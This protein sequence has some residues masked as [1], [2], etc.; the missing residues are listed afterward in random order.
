M[1]SALSV[2]QANRWRPQC[3]SLVEKWVDRWDYRA[4]VQYCIY[5]RNATNSSC[6]AKM[7][8]LLVTFWLVTV[9][10]F[11]CIGANGTMATLQLLCISCR[12]HPDCWLL[13]SYYASVVN[14]AILSA[15]L[16]LNYCPSATHDTMA[17]C[18][19]AKNMHQVIMIPWQ[20]VAL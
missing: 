17:S 6:I 9:H 20:L 4:K 18:Y 11:M 14:D 16:L 13:Y 19:N 10:C 7:Q 3:G 8:Q 5:Q 2:K 15:A 12:G 1:V